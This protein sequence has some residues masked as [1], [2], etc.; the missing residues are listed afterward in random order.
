MVSR[1]F[2]F[3]VFT[4]VISVFSFSSKEIAEVMFIGSQQAPS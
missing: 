3:D 2:G 4:P 1:L